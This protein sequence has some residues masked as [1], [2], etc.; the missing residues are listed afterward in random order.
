MREGG[1]PICE[2]QML[3]SDSRDAIFERVEDGNR[4][5]LMNVFCDALVQRPQYRIWC[6]N[7]LAA[8][9]IMNAVSD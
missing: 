2:E 5:L 8:D 3:P 4:S 1:T 7:S 9:W 6:Q